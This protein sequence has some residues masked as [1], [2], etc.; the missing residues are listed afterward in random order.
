[1]LSSVTQVLSA[2]PILTI[3]VVIGLGYVLGEIN[4]FGVRFGV[5]GVLFVGLAAGALSPDISVPE[6]VPTL[7]LILFIYTI[8]IQS[9]SAFFESFRKQ[10]WR[11]SL[12]V[13]VL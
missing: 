11:D 8:G 7:G 4:F 6:L 3:F 5:V 1:M 13:V 12:F 10:G 2:N 9:G